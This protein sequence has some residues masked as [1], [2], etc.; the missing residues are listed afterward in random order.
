MGLRTEPRLLPSHGGFQGPTVDFPLRLETPKCWT[1]SPSGWGFERKAV[2]HAPTSLGPKSGLC[3]TDDILRHTCSVYSHNPPQAPELSSAD[4]AR[5]AARLQ[6]LTL[7]LEALTKGLQSRPNPSLG[8][9]SPPPASSL[10]TVGGG[11]KPLPGR[12]SLLGR[13]AAGLA[14]PRA[15]GARAPACVGAGGEAL[16]S[17]QG[18]S[19]DSPRRATEPSRGAAILLSRGFP[20]DQDPCASHWLIQGVPA[21]YHRLCS[22]S[23]GPRV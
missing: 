3:L 17:R 19:R 2:S 12:G 21:G 5:P 13:P 18:L 9:A 10:A 7:Q 22:N 6:A 15:L 20:G 1:V 14:G 8:A 4:K 23:I 16:R 11:S